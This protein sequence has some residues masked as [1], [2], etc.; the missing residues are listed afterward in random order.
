MTRR[1]VP[2]GDSP[3]SRWRAGRSAS[4]AAPTAFIRSAALSVSMIS[5]SATERSLPARWASGA[6]LPRE[7]LADA[8]AVLV[9]R[10]AGVGE[11]LMLER[12]RH[13]ADG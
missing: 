4:M 1:Q 8:F 6:D 9:S 3:R 11:P 2:A 10:A 12:G 13:G 7:R 5:C